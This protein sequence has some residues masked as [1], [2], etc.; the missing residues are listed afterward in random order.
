[1]SAR[2]VAEEVGENEDVAED[3]DG[4]DNVKTNYTKNKNNKYPIDFFSFYC[5]H[6]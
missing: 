6:V 1:M 5:P 4:I 3:L 2:T